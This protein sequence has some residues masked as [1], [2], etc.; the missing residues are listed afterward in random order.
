MEFAVGSKVI[1]PAHGTAE[2]VG[3]S[4]RKI[5]GEEVNYLELVGRRR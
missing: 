5:D 3:R 4:V 1:Y 2:V